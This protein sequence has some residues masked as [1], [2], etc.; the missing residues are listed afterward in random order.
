MGKTLFKLFYQNDQ[1]HSQL[2]ENTYRTLFRH[3]D[4]PLAE[5][6]GKSKNVPLL[7][8]NQQNSV[9]N[10]HAA[11]TLAFSYS[12]FGYTA[13]LNHEYS[14]LAFT[15]HYRQTLTGHYLLGNGYRLYSPGLMRFFSPDSLSPFGLGGPNA[16]IYC[17]GDPVNYSDPSGRSGRH[18]AKRPAPYARVGSTRR[19]NALDNPIE[20]QGQQAR[21]QGQLQ[22]ADTAVAGRVSPRPGTSSGVAVGAP[23]AQ[24][25]P[26][27]LRTTHA[28]PL[29]LTT[30]R[31]IEGRIARNEHLLNDPSNGAFVEAAVLEIVGLERN[32]APDVARNKF[33]G[34]LSVELGDRV[35][36]KIINKV[37][38]LRRSK[39]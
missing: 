32:L 24:D 17:S 7:A 1:L 28:A 19:A 37:S 9:M 26:L 10:T 22:R 6:Q 4:L 21:T 23:P 13:R 3:K 38:K 33:I 16:Y 12:P 18:A 36:K 14:L 8:T 35:Y 2:S 11:G 39:N 27:D 20:Q 29:D 31:T 30:P 25:A 5:H 34:G 15:G